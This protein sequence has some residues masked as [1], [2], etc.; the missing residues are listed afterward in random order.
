MVRPEDFQVSQLIPQ[1]QLVVSLKLVTV[2]RSTDALK[3]FATVWITGVQS[4]DEPGR[5]DVVHMAPD[6]CLFEIHSARFNLT[7][8]AYSGSPPIPPSFPQRARSRPLPLYAG[9]SVQAS[10]GY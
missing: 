3:V 1:A 2:A 7:L 5:H 8:P 9:S 10:L 6:F 4:P